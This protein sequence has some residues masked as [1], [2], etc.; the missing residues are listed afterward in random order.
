MSQ[1]DYEELVQRCAELLQRC[2][3]AAYAGGSGGDSSLAELARQC[4][5]QLERERL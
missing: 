1:V 4:A 2:E 3:Q 5:R